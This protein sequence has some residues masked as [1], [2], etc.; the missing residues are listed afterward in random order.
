MTASKL[1]SSVLF[2][3]L[4]TN[5]FAQKLPVVQTDSLI[6]HVFEN[7]EH[8]TVWSIAPEARPDVFETYIKGESN[9]VTFKNRNDSLS[10]KV[11]PGD[12]YSFVFLVNEKDSAFTEIR[13]IKETPRARFSDE[14]VGTHK[15]KTFV[16][17][18]AV[19]ELLNIVFAL[20]N[21]GKTSP[22]LI[23]KDTPYYT[24]AMKWFAPYENE[25]IIKN[26][27]AALGESG[28]TYSA[29]KMDAYAFEFSGQGQ[30]V[31]SKV[32]DR[33]GN[34]PANHLRPYI[35]DLQAFANKSKFTDFYKKH[36]DYYQKLIVAFRDS[37]G[38][39]DMQKWLNT[40]F[41][42]TR[43]DSFKIIFSPLVGN[44]QSAN[45]F[46]DNGF[47]EAQA[48]VNFPF[49]DK[50]KPGKWSEKAMLVADGNLVFTE[51]NHS[52]INP[53]GEK[54]QYKNAI[55]EAFGNL[56]TWNEKGKPAAL[57]Y[58]N[59]YSSFHEHLN[60]GLVSLRYVDFA[61]KKEQAALISS[62]ENVLVAYRGFKKFGTFNQ[63]LVNIYK[64][65]KPGQTVA[66]LYPAIVKW[67]QDNR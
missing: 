7:G 2:L 3:L 1:L 42:T 10:F 6:W 53:E 65:R 19:Y 5:V 40:N 66:D 52:F 27:N 48:H 58:N 57:S 13:G 26:V 45:W 41:P 23:Y 54:P 38:I 33:I 35:N 28:D 31:H 21:K 67:F 14:Y 49:R 64:T 39:P 12:T 9:T 18:P 20:T 62:I 47:R 25:P 50:T 55:E 37:V 22:G 32:Y 4:F 46:S 34:S 30:I 43:Y 63:F 17:I 59:A 51:L 60:W 11:K 36:K 61:P 15:G 29:L 16:E 56:D 24:E 8:T 44:N